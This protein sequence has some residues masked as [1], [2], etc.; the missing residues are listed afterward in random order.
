MRAVGP[1]S[2]WRADAAWQ[3]GRLPWS[4]GRV[5]GRGLRRAGGARPLPAAPDGTVGHGA[6]RRAGP[7]AGRG[8]G[9]RGGARRRWRRGGGARPGVV[10]RG[11]NGSHPPPLCDAPPAPSP[12]RPARRRQ[13]RQHRPA[14]PRTGLCSGSPA[15]TA[16]PP[17]T[18]PARRSFPPLPC[19]PRSRPCRAPRR[20]RG[21]EPGPWLKEA[22]FQGSTKPIARLGPRHV[23][24]CVLRT[25]WVVWVIGDRL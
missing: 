16:L 9:G 22:D 13:R 18:A 17:L 25:Q 3:S 2:Q 21:G 1:S 11:G 10:Q 24:S 23:R 19:A 15:L 4:V 6:G 7:G 20:C 14:P 8:A 12:P 5:R